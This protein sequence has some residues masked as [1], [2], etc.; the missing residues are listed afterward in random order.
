MT[1]IDLVGRID[2]L[3]GD[4]GANGDAIEREKRDVPS[5]PWT[6]LRWNLSTRIDVLP[7]IE[8][9]HRRRERSQREHRIESRQPHRVGGRRPGRHGYRAAH[10][11]RIRV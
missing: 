9:R 1:S 4:R 3:V 7:A 2:D 8:Q 6:R 10:V 11:Q 5:L